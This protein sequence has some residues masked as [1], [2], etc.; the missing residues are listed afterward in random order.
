MAVMYLHTDEQPRA[1]RE[2]QR[3][4]EMIQL[5]EDQLS[6]RRIEDT[7]SANLNAIDSLLFGGLSQYPGIFSE[8][9]V[10]LKKL[11]NDDIPIWAF[12]AG[13][14]VLLP[15]PDML[16]RLDTPEILQ[17]HL[18]E[19]GKKDPIFSTLD[20]LFYSACY[21]QPFT[22]FNRECGVPLAQT[23]QG[24]VVAFRKS[25]RNAYATLFNPYRYK[26]IVY[27][28]FKKYVAQPELL[29]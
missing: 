17:I 15:D 2:Y 1:D 20:D 26:S 25:D 16:L 13:S 3:I 7:N 10:L 28:F 19:E 22:L 21:F 12:E 29:A 4:L 23:K 14:V 9:K 5:D 11:S 6:A 24:Q 27:R 18:T 8:N